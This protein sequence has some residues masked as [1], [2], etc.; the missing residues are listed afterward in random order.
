M[1]EGKRTAG[2]IRP[3]WRF[4]AGI[5]LFFL[6]LLSPLFIP[7]VTA[8]AL[9]AAWKTAGSGLLMLG[10]P[11]LLW[12]AAAAIMGKSGFNYIKGKFWGFFKKMAPPD[13]VS[14]A[15]YR[16]GLVMFS[17]PILFG[18]VGPYGLHWIQGYE[19]YRLAANLIGDILLI[20][21]LFV[22]GGDFW[23]KMRGLF[24]HKAKIKIPALESQ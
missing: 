17:L 5:I 21:S 10:I 14:P 9:P 24:I 7:L 16:V 8:T 13:E 18:W 23:D 19:N 2:H 6:G 20:S 4:Y 12:V 11:E 22:L 1:T 15:R 3:G